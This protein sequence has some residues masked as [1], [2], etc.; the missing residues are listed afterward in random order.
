MAS[1]IIFN[2][3]T[4]SGQAAAGYV[5]QALLGAKSLNANYLQ[6]IPNVKKRRVL[7]TIEQDVVFQDS[8]CA[9]SAAG[10]TTVGERYLDPVSMSVMYELCY[11]DLQDSWEADRLNAGANSGN[12]PSDLALFLISRMQEKIANGIEK[13][14]WLGKTGSEFG[15]TGTYPGFFSLMD[16]N[17]SVSKIN[18]NIGQLAISGISIAANAVVTVASTTNLKTGNKVT[19]IGANAAT[20]VGGVAISGQ[21]FSITVLSS[22]TFSIGATTTG[23][24]TGAAGFV[25]FINQS[26]VIDVLTAVYNS[27]PDAIK[28]HP[29]F[30]F[31]VPMHVADAYRLAQSSVAT[32]AGS[33]FT[34]D[35]GLNFLGKPLAEMPY[36]KANTILATR[37][38]N[39]YFGTDL[40]ADMNQVQVV[41]MR[42]TTA[43]Q[44]VRFRAAFSSDVNY[45][46]G[47]EVLLYR[48]A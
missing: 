5:S 10:N 4:Y 20:L 15:F 27:L 2:P 42:A 41:D 45:A 1:Q 34:N 33:W 16:T 28:H 43:D 48:P 22:T 13:L 36:F 14:I 46:F 19:I 37:K 3:N 44:K 35:K 24:A 9:F 40:L 17:S 11:H 30:S 7:R 18:G 38:T 39:L 12:V 26:N 25:Q 8:A 31:F 32:G 6:V 21:T 29:Q 23:T 47:E